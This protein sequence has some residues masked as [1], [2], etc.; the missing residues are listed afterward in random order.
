MQRRRW[1]AMNTG[2]ALCMKK[3]TKITCEYPIHV[4][5]TALKKSRQ[6]HAQNK[7]CGKLS[8]RGAG[9][10]KKRVRFEM[11][12]GGNSRAS[13]AR[14]ADRDDKVRRTGRAGLQ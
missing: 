1:L 5:C 13:S 7:I 12:P 6:A 9:K 10:R 4:P 3:F 11:R 14:N 8:L 2:Y